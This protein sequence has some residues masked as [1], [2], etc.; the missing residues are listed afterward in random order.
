MVVGDSQLVS[1]VHH[2]TL[3]MTRQ[4]DSVANETDTYSR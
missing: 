3:Q 1:P 2:S 4:S